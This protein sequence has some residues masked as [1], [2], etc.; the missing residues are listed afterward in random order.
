MSRGKISVKKKKGGGNESKY[1]YKAAFKIFCEFFSHKT[2]AR[3]VIYVNNSQVFT[4]L[5]VHPPLLYE[6][7]GGDGRKKKVK[8]VTKRR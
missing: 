6:G 1:E 4:I 2:R 8:Y 5:S 7:E 3:S